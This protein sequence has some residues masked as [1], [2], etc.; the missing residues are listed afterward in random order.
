MKRED[1]TLLKGKMTQRV[2]FKPRKALFDESGKNQ[3]IQIIQEGA[4]CELKEKQILNNG[5]QTITIKFYFKP[6]ENEE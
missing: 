3:L 4:I 6:T 1:K 5:A 2:I